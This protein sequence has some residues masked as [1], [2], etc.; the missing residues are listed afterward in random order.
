[1]SATCVTKFSRETYYPLSE[2]ALVWLQPLK[3]CRV[4]PS[5]MRWLQNSL[6]CSLS[7]LYPRRDM[8]YWNS[9][10]AWREQG[11]AGSG[12]ESQ[13]REI[14][15]WHLK[16]KQYLMKNELQLCVGWCV[17]TTECKWLGMV[18]HSLSEY[19]VYTREARGRTPRPAQYSSRQAHVTN[20]H[21]KRSQST[22]HFRRELWRVKY[23]LGSK[24]WY[25][26]KGKIPY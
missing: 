5:T 1:M 3:P 16:M 19:L 22:T 24:A 6:P 17:T 10:A 15:W 4:V 12:Q 2:L 14:S 25:R 20:E 18:D 13:F 23:R 8:C 7:W 11:T 21:L 26:K 9:Y